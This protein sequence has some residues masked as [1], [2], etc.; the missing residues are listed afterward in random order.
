[1][2]YLA[3]SSCSFT[4]HIILINI[5][6]IHHIKVKCVHDTVILDRLLTHLLLLACHFLEEFLGLFS[7]KRREEAV[8][9]HYP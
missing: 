8:Q 1:M 9:L 3:F 6:T 5:I 7:A 4:H 2:V